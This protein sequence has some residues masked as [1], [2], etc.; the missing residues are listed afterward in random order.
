MFGA[1]GELET[2][3]ADLRRRG[4]LI[5]LDD[6]GAGYAG[7]QQMI[8]IAPDILKLDRTLVHGAHADGSRQALLEALIG[9]ASSTGAAICAEGRRGPRRPARA[10]GAGR[11][12][13]A[14]VRPVP[15]RAR[16]AAAG[17][18]GDRG[19]RVGDPRRHA[20]R[21]T[22]HGGAGAFARGLA[23]LSDELSSRHDRAAT[24]A[25]PTSG[26][27]RCSGADELALLL[28]RGNEIEL[29]SDEPRGGRRALVARR[30]PRRR[31][32]C[33]STGVPGQVV[34]GDE[35]GDAAELAEL[36]ELGLGHGPARARH[37]Q[38][39]AAGAARG[40]PRARRRRSPPR[41][42]DRAR[43]LAQQFGAALDRLPD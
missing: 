24:S 13:R 40:L 41:E 7:L 29:V 8:R 1:E 26:P 30:L 33:S 6:A 5:A 31:A 34:V 2:A 43:V 21:D 42:I 28:V 23:E 4:A 14:G 32:T 18:R 16:V 3:L 10:R 11:D 35:A 15:P 39:R 38:R 22:R 12:L 19:E 25:R 36:A 27:R 17:R 9:F 37:L 20:H